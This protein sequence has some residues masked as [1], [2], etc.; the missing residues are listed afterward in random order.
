MAIKL[1][2]FDP[3]MCCSSGVCGP[4]VDKKLVMFSAALEWLRSR[5]VAVRRY[6]PTQEYAAF[7]SNAAVVQAINERGTECLPLI[8]VDGGIV[9]MGGY[10][11][12]NEL[13]VLVGIDGEPAAN[14]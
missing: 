12:R 14:A 11:A 9:S 7:A 5:G 2:V 13:A 6:N 3:P 1:E 10:P 8:L 4:K